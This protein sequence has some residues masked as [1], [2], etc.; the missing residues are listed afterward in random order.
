MFMIAEK[1]SQWLNSRVNKLLRRQIVNQ[2]NYDSNKLVWPGMWPQTIYNYIEQYFAQ[3][4]SKISEHYVAYKILAV[5][6]F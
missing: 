2:K 1:N 3:I 6:S 5:E 4:T